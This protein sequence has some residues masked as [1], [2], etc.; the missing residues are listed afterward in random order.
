MTSNPTERQIESLTVKTLPKIILHAG[1]A[2][3]AALVFVLYGCNSDAD[4]DKRAYRSPF[5]ALEDYASFLERMSAIDKADS[6]ELIELVKEWKAL[7]DTIASRFFREPYGVGANRTDTSYLCIRDTII[8]HFEDLAGSGKRTLSDYTL[9]VTSVS[10]QPADSTTAELM[11]SMHRF[12]GALDATPTYGVNAKA[13]ITKYEALLDSTLVSGFVSKTAVFDY[14]KSEDK[15]FRSFLEHLAS[16]DNIPLTKVRDDTA[17]TMKLI[18]GLASEEN[19]MFQP[20]ELVTILT[21]RNNRRLLQNALQC[22]NDIRTGK[23]GRDDRAYAYMWMIIQPWI[24]FDSLSYSL[25]SETQ[26][27]TMGILAAETTKCVEK[28]GNPDFPIDIEEL[29]TLLMRTFISTL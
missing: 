12:F 2:F 13:T 5:D 28:L 23:V 25:M 10:K 14:L 8:M 24:S 11:M 15:A 27:K 29:P 19:G 9:L 7:D 3:I 21:M 16:L 22:V 17:E 26:F 20:T 18:I 4:S 6:K 1:K